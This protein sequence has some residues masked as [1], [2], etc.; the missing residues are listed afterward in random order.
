MSRP[1]FIGPMPSC[2]YEPCQ[3]ISRTKGF[4]EAHYA[5]Q[6]A[7]KMLKPI[8][9]D[10]RNIRYFDDL[11]KY[12][13]WAPDGKCVLW[14]RSTNSGGYGLQNFEN[15]TWPA[16]RLSYYLANGKPNIE[17]QVVHHKCA[18]R[19]CINPDHLELAT[20]ADNLLEMHARK[21][22]EAEIKMLRAR[23]AELEAQL[24]KK[25][26]TILR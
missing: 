14:T 23:V 24:E 8:W 15:R 7:G 17:G 21:S 6:R 4:C 3:R 10:R 1:R 20:H 18:V 16:H 25:G 13:V 11:L 19:L 26:V 9:E 12:T 22:M 2:S 5:Q